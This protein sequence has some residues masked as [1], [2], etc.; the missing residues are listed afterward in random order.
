MGIQ[1]FETCTTYLVQNGIPN[2][3]QNHFLGIKI[4][5]M[6]LFETCT[7]Y[8]VQN[9][10]PNSIKV[11]LFGIKSMEMQLFETCTTFLVQNGI[12]NSTKRCLEPHFRSGA[13]QD[14]PGRPA[15]PAWPPEGN[16]GRAKEGGS[17][18]ERMAP[19]HS[20]H[21]RWVIWYAHVRTCGIE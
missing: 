9:G 16:E 8:L 12:P 1:L 19:P 6:Q 11:S 17:A 2:S 18:Q 20:Y 4:M 14:E 13:V 21:R 10:T 7:T 3:T 5:E 15:R